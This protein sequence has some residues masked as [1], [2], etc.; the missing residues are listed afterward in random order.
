[1]GSAFSTAGSTSGATLPITTTEPSRCARAAAA[2]ASMSTQ[3]ATSPKKPRM[4][5]GS[6]ARSSGIGVEGSHAFTKWLKSTPWRTST[7]LGFT[8]AL[9]SRSRSAEVM[10]RSARRSSFSSSSA[11][12]RPL[13]SLKAEN[14]STQW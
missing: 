1:L 10:T 8:R 9:L 2:M 3:S 12:C 7:V 11:M 4:G 6:F 5:L 13:V 14:S